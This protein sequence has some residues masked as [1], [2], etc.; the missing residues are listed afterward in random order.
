M[1]RLCL[2]A[3]LLCA[4]G[5]GREPC[6]EG[7]WAG[8]GGR[9][10]ARCPRSR[11][12]LSGAPQRT[13]GTSPTRPAGGL[14]GA[15]PCLSGTPHSARARRSR[16]RRSRACAPP[17]SRSRSPRPPRSR[18]P[19]PCSR[20]RRAPP[21]P[22]PRPRA[23]PR[24]RLR[25]RRSPGGGA[26][27]ALAC[28]CTL[29]IAATSLSSSSSSSSSSFFQARPTRAHTCP[30][31]T[32]RLCGGLGA[33]VA[34]DLRALRLWQSS[35]QWHAVPWSCIDAAPGC[36]ALRRSSNNIL[37]AWP[38]RVAQAPRAGRS[39][40]PWSCSPHWRSSRQP[41]G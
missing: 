16:C 23:R 7:G 25:A 28:C 20:H 11:P 26:L 12:C 14:R 41:H 1:I 21:R 18:S 13:P 9:R 2:C 6:A 32:W 8:R 37:T 36:R 34:R 40:T 38:G 19:R 17:R 29:R 30:G 15:R 27:A 10:R 35:R 3:G 39:R 33:S 24:P 22:I 5:S 31:I 4:R